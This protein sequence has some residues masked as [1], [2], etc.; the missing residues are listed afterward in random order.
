MIITTFNK[1]RTGDFFRW[2]GNNPLAVFVKDSNNSY[3]HFGIS[4]S[5]TITESAMDFEVMLLVHLD[6][7]S[8]ESK[9]KQRLLDKAELEAEI[10]ALREKLKPL[11]WIDLDAGAT[12]KF[13]FIADASVCVRTD[14]DSYVCL[15]TGELVDEYNVAHNNVPVI[16]CRLDGGPYEDH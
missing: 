16:L 12:F 1:L 9:L 14:D 13:Q 5:E 11:Y 7:D 2:M 10:E 8:D 3:R 4:D 15:S 6:F